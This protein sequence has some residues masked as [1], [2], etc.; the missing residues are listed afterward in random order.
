MRSLA[1][2]VSLIAAM[3]LTLAPASFAD[4]N[5]GKGKDKSW[6][7]EKKGKNGESEVEGPTAMLRALSESEQD[8]LAQLVLEKEYGFS[9]NTLPPGTSR[10]LP[11]GLKKKLERGGTLPPGWQKKLQRGEKI[12]PEVYSQAERIPDELLRRVTGRDDAVELLRVGDRILR[13]MEGRGT[14]LDVIDLSDR[15]IRMLESN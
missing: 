11:P 5:E 12:D 6:K 4:K 10:E 8:E 15:A 7:A 3:G 14:V 13:V 2:A 1:L 9:K